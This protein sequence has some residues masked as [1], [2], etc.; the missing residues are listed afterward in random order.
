M[1]LRETASQVVIPANGKWRSYKEKK[2]TARVNWFDSWDDAHDF[3]INKERDSIKSLQDQIEYH[4]KELA[5]I[6][7]MAR[8]IGA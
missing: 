8:P 5:A 4:E 7:L 1:R 3:L 6:L 2:R